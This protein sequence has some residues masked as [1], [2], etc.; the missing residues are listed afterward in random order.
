MRTEFQEVADVDTSAIPGFAWME[1]EPVVDASL[2]ALAS[3]DVICVPGL[4]NR[5]LSTLTRALPH[6]ASSRIA[7]LF[8]ERW[9][10]E[11]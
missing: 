10:P 8:S 11:A 9:L 3:G 1:P 7:S 2:A 4:A 5:A 6:A